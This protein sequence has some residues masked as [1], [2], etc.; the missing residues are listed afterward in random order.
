MTQFIWAEKSGEILL[1]FWA[2]HSAFL[3]CFNNEGKTVF[4]SG[5]F[6]SFYHLSCHEILLLQLQG[7]TTLGIMTFTIMI[8]G[9]MAFSIMMLDTKCCYAGCHLSWVSF[10]LSVTKKPFVLRAVAPVR[11]TYEWIDFPRPL[12]F[13]MFGYF[14]SGKRQLHPNHDCFLFVTASATFLASTTGCT[15]CT[16]WETSDSA[17]SVT[18]PCPGPNIIKLFCP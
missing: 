7:A 5:R 3:S 10:M 9:I 18:N 16:A 12:N 2:T 14:H 15:P 13:F 11:C 1:T 6:M 8:L 4:F 17:P